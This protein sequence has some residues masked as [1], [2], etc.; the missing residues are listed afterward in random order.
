MPVPLISRFLGAALVLVG[1]VGLQS[2]YGDLVFAGGGFLQTIKAGSHLVPLFCC[3]VVG[4]GAKAAV[5][6]LHGWLPR[7]MIAPTPVSALLHAVAVVKAGVFGI[8]RVVYSIYG[9]QVLS[10]LGIAGLLTVLAMATMVVALF[11]ALRQDVLKLRLAYS[12]VAQLSYIILG[13][14]MLSSWGLS[15]ALMHLVNHALFKV[16]LFFAAGII[17]SQ[18]GVDRI[19][20]MSGIARRFPLT[21]LCF[22]LASLA[23]VGVLPTNGF[24]GKWHL[25]TG[26]LEAGQFIPAAVLILSALLS[27]LYILPISVVALFRP[28]EREKPPGLEAPASMLVPVATLAGLGL[29]VGLFPG[30]LLRLAGW[31]TGAMLGQP[32][33]FGF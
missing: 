26:S 14:S 6:S 10:E 7:A 4:F 31:V 1:I 22:G 27:A 17:I 32:V 16:I 2:S 23:L 20:Q 18:S 8:L 25:I 3:L 21:M 13:A 9:V 5:M 19:S 12:T 24:L 30:P 29:L 15:G 33:E 11:I 28:G